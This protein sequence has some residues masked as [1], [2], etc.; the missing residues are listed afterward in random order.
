MAMARSR[1]SVR[2][3]PVS[4]FALVVILGLS[5]LAVLSAATSRVSG[6]EAQ[7]Q[8]EYTASAYANDAAAADALADVD[9][10]L[11][12]E[13]EAQSSSGVQVGSA[14]EADS[15]ANA[16]SA[17]EASYDA[18]AAME[19]VAAALP[20]GEL[21]SGISV[22]SSVDGRKA[23]MVFSAQDGRMLTVVLRVCDNLTYELEQ[24]KVT[25]EWNRE[26]EENRLWSG[27]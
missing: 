5:V 14:A 25:T 9:A 7:A 17:S 23:Q 3:G 12:R 13:A 11:A 26:P 18:D 22:V 24:W 6:I 16:D 20:Q 15:D 21:E 27:Q 4:V 10:A 8:A 1:G 19:A 2:I